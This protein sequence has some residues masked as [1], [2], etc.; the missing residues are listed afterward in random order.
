MTD[1]AT[2]SG[3]I[4]TS[5]RNIKISNNSVIDATKFYVKKGNA[6]IVN[7]KIQGGSIIKAGVLNL[8]NSTIE[9]STTETSYIANLINASTIRNSKIIA[10]DNVKAENLR[11]YD[12]EILSNLKISVNNGSELNSVRLYAG[13]DISIEGSRVLNNSSLAADRDL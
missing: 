6:D 2:V 12:S 1:N 5:E 9:N 7:S 4:L 10:G 13:S 3:S 11:A 8:Q